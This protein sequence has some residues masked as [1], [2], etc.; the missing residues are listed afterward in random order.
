M[1]SNMTFLSLHLSYY[2]PYF[3]IYLIHLVKFFS[4][5]YANLQ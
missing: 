2:S 1:R 4:S 5:P 3:I